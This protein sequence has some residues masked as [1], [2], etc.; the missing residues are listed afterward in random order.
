LLGFLVLALPV[1]LDIV[2]TVVLDVLALL[3][4]VHLLLVLVAHFAKH[5]DLI[6]RLC[7]LP[8]AEN[9]QVGA[10]GR[11][12]VPE[13]RGWWISQVFSSLPAHRIGGPNHKVIAL[14][15]GRLVLKAGSAS[16][17]PAAEHDDIA[18]GDIHAVS[19]SMLWWSSA[20]SQTRPLVVLSVQNPN[21][22]QV[23]LSKSSALILSSLLHIFFVIPEASV[24]HQ[25]CSDQDSA[26]A[27]P[28]AGSRARAFRLGPSHNL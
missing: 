11:C 9:K 15:L 14:L 7:V 18:A 17:R 16:S 23:A 5:D 22:I 3:A 20:D 13:S 10:D 6:L 12:C 28:R 1:V 25:I 8:T 21:V 4:L 24:D 19:E 26:M 2:L 27:F